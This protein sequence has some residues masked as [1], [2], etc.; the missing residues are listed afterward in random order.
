MTRMTAASRTGATALVLL[1][2]AACSTTAATPQPHA[3]PT[4][5][6][7]PTTAP[8]AA[9][10]SPPVSQGT[11][12]VAGRLRDGLPVRAAGLSWRPSPLPPGTRL[13]SFEVGYAWQACTALSGGKG[14]HCSAGADATETPFAARR[15]V[16][17]HGDTGKTTF[18][19]AALFRRAR[20]SAGVPSPR[21]TPSA[22][23]SRRSG[24]AATR[25]TSRAPT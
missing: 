2:A 17:G 15:Y 1:V 6:Q 25:R 24:R 4:P 10:I 8:P 12:R 9:A 3:S 20:S 19:E 14:R 13:L 11:L 16:T 21:R 18:V 7:S 22:T 23:T 5:R